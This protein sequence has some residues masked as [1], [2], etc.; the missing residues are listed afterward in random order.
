M[1]FDIAHHS[2]VQGIILPKTVLA[3]LLFTGIDLMLDGVEG[4]L[5][6]P[7]PF[8]S[9]SFPN[10]YGPDIHGRSKDPLLE[11][12]SRPSTRRTLPGFFDAGIV[13]SLCGD[14][15]GDRQGVVEEGV[16]VA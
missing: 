12:M 9:L 11:N 5:R 6:I 4:L 15:K 8:I 13:A 2:V 14:N 16:A 1:P 3:L 10:G 7:P